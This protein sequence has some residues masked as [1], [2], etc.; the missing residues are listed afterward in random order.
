M[1]RRKRRSLTGAEAFA[2]RL[3]ALREAAGL[4]QRELAHK[5]GLS[6]TVV[7]KYELGA[8][9]PVWGSLLALAGALGA[10]LGDFTPPPARGKKRGG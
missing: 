8:R 9:E 6:L 10:S 3:R 2:E 5:A 7:S 1:P 4:S